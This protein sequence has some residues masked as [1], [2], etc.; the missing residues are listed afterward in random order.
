MQDDNSWHFERPLI[1]I[2]MELVVADMVER[3]VC[4]TIIYGHLVQRLKRAQQCR[5]IIRHACP[6]GRQRRKESDLQPFFRGPNRAVPMRTMV[7]P[8]SIAASRSC[9]IPIERCG[10]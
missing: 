2:A 8:S 3:D 4:V 9:D 1:D 7:A 10:R 5:R 6:G